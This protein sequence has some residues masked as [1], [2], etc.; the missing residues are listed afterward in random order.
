ESAARTAAPLRVHLASGRQVVPATPE[1]VREGRGLARAPAGSAAGTPPGPLPWR[2]N[3][4]KVL[5]SDL[6]FPGEPDALLGA[7]ASGHGVGVVLA[8]F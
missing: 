3:A 8:P 7:L 6:L 2:G 5:V 4:L 1:L